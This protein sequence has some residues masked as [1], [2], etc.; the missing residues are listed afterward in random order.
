MPHNLHICTIV[1]Y[2]LIHKDYIYICMWEWGRD[3]ARY[4][5]IYNSITFDKLFV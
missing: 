2:V 3:V 1:I 4:I 5:Y